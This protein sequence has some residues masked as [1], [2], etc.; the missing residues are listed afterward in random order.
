[1]GLVLKV[2]LAIAL[3]SLTCFVFA[4]SY[5]INGPT[6]ASD[7][8]LNLRLGTTGVGFDA[9]KTFGSDFKVRLGYSGLNYKRNF[10]S[11]DNT[12]VGKLKL[13]GADL[14][15]DYHP[16]S[17]GF[18]VTGGLYAPNYKFIGVAAST[19]TGTV[20]LNGNTYTSAQVSS[21]SGQASWS[22]V[23]P[24]LGVGYDGFNATRKGDFFFTYDMGVTFLGNPSTSLNANCG[25]SVSATLCNKINADA[26]AEKSSFD[27]KTGNL[28]FFPVIQLGVGYR[29]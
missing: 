9:T 7:Y 24:Y 29:F 21:V 27:S 25:A 1:M 13:G 4:Q 16:F 11:T 2:V 3:S 15:A 19:Q 22:G 20:K 10:D 5:T 28:K 17:S 8:G 26:Q 18:R 6:N 23:K 14:L 12:F